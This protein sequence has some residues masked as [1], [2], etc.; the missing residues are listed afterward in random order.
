[1]GSNG[2]CSMPNDRTKED[3]R[4]IPEVPDIDCQS[5]TSEDALVHDIIEGMR[6]AGLCV[7]RQ[8]VKPNI[9]AKIRAEMRP[10]VPQA[11][12]TPG[13]FWPRETTKISS[14]LSKSETY[15]LHLVGHPVWQRVG[16]YFLTSTLE[17]YWVNPSAASNSHLLTNIQRELTLAHSRRLERRQDR[18]QRL[19]APT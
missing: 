15:A 10:H 1:M 12:T 16:E 8:I 13:D 14:M 2:T 4:P 5:Y 9:L 19:Q 7:V 11:A 17:N 18:H 3:P 6:N